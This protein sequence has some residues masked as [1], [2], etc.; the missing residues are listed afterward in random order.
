MAET[1][2]CESLPSSTL[3]VIGQ[4]L[5]DRVLFSQA[6]GLLVGLTGCTPDRAAHALLGVARDLDITVGEVARQLT[7]CM[8][9][10]DDR[11]GPIMARLAAAALGPEPAAIPDHTIWLDGPP[12]LPI[13]GSST[14]I[15]P[16]ARKAAMSSTT[17]PK[18]SR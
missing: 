4:S 5:C 14:R 3:I 11:A 12:R 2:P 10:D 9:I 17:S 1:A 18:N 7:R 8:S 15:G 6:Q 13:Q 16:P